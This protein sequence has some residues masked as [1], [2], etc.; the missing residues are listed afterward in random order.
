MSGNSG[1]QAEIAQATY[2]LISIPSNPV[3]IDNFRD[4]LISFYVE[5]AATGTS[6]YCVYMFPMAT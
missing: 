3:L 1:D 5:T 4:Q 6:P 2:V